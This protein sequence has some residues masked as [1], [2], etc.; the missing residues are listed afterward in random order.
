MPGQ[1]AFHTVYSSFISFHFSVSSCRFYGVRLLACSIQFVY[2]C[3]FVLSQ[4]VSLICFVIFTISRS[5]D[6]RRETD[7]REARR[8][9]IR[10][11]GR[12]DRG[13]KYVR[14]MNFQKFLMMKPSTRNH[15]L[16]APK[17]SKTHL[18]QSKNK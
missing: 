3:F 17:C 7:T 8:G 14:H 9:E 5:V 10:G 4:N 15:P 13:G 18:Q 6:C 1:S 12:Q 16:V 2:A 11:E